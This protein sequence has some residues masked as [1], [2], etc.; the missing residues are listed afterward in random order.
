MWQI[1]RKSLL[2]TGALVI[3]PIYLLKYYRKLKRDYEK[4]LLF[5]KRH[6]CVV[7]YQPMKGFFGWPL[8]SE[9]ENDSPDVIEELYEPIMYFIRTAQHSLD[10]CVMHLTVNCL[11]SELVTAKRRGVRIRIL[12]NFPANKTGIQPQIRV[13]IDAGNKAN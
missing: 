5:S 1:N 2:I 10:L 9:G 7:T 6:N 11:V 4:R 3:I 12:L 8:D 13:L